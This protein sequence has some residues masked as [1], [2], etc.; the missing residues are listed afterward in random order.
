M[1]LHYEGK[2]SGEDMASPTSPS[3]SYASAELLL[4]HGTLAV[5][6]PDFFFLTLLM[7]CNTS[8]TP[9]NVIPLVPLVH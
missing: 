2:Y 7:P 9:T 3:H 5:S 1:A 8:I 6:F 4:S